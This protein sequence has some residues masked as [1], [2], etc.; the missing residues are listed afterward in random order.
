MPVKQN[1]HLTPS[2]Y[3][4]R[5]IGYPVNCFCKL[6]KVDA[7]CSV[8]G[9]VVLTQTACNV[10]RNQLTVKGSSAPSYHSSHELSPAL[11]FLGRDDMINM[12]VL[13]LICVSWFVLGK[14]F[15]LRKKI[16][17]ME[18]LNLSFAVR[19]CTSHNADGDNNVVIASLKCWA[20]SSEFV[21]GFSHYLDV[22]VIGRN[23]P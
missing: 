18:H 23:F 8:D 6:L 22:H 12:P 7:L 2:K 17:K 21:P 3:R 14:Q 9:S 13:H 11:N 15:F 1:L 19:L 20:L 16:N 10:W 5:A 4:P